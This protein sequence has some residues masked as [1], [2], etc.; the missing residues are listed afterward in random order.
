MSHFRPPP[1]SSS[2]PDLYFNGHDHQLA[3]LRVAEVPDVNFFT[4]GAAGIASDGDTIAGQ[5]SNPPAYASGFL[6]S[7]APHGFAI[8][9][10]YNDTVGD[11][12]LGWPCTSGCVIVPN[13]FS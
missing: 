8:V 7:T 3:H 10:L 5:G 11:F 9:Q 6:L 1:R 13:M 2:R 12:L 4:S